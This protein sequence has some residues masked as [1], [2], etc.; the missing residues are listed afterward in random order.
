MSVTN[1]YYVKVSLLESV[2]VPFKTDSIEVADS[3]NK[4]CHMGTIA[5]GSKTKPL[6]INE[7]C[8]PVKRA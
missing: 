5:Y 4:H 8:L 3:N 2:L 7:R 6:S 1:V